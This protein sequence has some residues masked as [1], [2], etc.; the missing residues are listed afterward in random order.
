MTPLQFTKRY[1]DCRIFY[2][3]EDLFDVQS[4]WVRVLNGVKRQ[5]QGL[6]VNG[7]VAAWDMVNGVAG[8]NRSA[9][10]TGVGN[11]STNTEAGNAFTGAGM[12]LVR[13]AWVLVVGLWLSALIL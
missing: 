12:A 1:A 5:G 2:V 7:S 10:G 13:D 11:G 3:K 4:T 6:C 9:T 8:G